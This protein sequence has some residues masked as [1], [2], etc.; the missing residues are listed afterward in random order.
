[1]KHL[2][3]KHNIYF[4]QCAVFTLQLQLQIQVDNERG[5]AQLVSEQRHCVVNAAPCE[6]M[7]LMEITADNGTGFTDKMRFKY[8]MRYIVQP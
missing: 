6:I 8:R 7:H 4:K 5:F 2:L 1:M 3:T